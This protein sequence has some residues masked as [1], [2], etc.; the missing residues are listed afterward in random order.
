[1]C[2]WDTHI[3]KL[4]GEKLLNSKLFADKKLDFIYKIFIQYDDKKIENPFE[5]VGYFAEKKE[6]FK[7]KAESNVKELDLMRKF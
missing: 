5:K 2:R 3:T 1:M 6:G 4:T 7:N